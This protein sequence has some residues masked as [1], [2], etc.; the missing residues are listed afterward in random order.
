MALGEFILP[1]DGARQADGSGSGNAPAAPAFEV[2]IGSQPANAPKVS[3]SAWDF[4]SSE[5]HILFPGLS[6][7]SDYVSG[8]TLRLIFKMLSATS[9]NILMKAA[10][11][12]AVNLSTDDDAII[13]SSVTT[14]GAVSVPGT[15]G[16]V[17]ELTIALTMTNAAPNRKM[18]LMIGS[19]GTGWTAAGTLRLMSAKFEYVR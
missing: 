9:G 5:Q 3:Q 15:Q 14:S 12:I 8:G 18:V 6:V 4:T 10:V 1:L 13:F 2:S 16:Q 17:K 7:P 19:E 11:A